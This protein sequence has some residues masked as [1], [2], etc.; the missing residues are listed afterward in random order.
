MSLVSFSH[1]EIKGNFVIMATNDILELPEKEKI[2][3][4]VKE[5]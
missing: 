1:Q 5:K 3:V 2:D 4:I